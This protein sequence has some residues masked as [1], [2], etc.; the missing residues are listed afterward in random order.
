MLFLMGY[1]SFINDF[2]ILIRENELDT[3]NLTVMN[4]YSL[5][6]FR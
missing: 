6:K 5:I 2:S 1:F 4:R 3:F